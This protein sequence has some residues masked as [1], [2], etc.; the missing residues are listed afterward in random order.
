MTL[1]DYG[2]TK[3]NFG[4][5]LLHSVIITFAGLLVLMLVLIFTTIS[6]TTQFNPLNILFY[7][8][9]SVP[10]QEVIFRGFVQTRLKRFLP[11][12][13]SIIITSLLF[14]SI[15]YP[16][17]TTVYLTFV[18][19]IFWGYSFNKEPNLAGPIISHMVLGV[20]LVYLFVF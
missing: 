14:C 8:F 20:C 4:A 9:I 12:T 16:S 10:V 7:I 13:A 5:S 18:A 15:H 19:S 17:M 1:T 3:S 11:T 6:F 2:I